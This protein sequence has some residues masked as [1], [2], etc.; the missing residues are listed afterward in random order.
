[1][2]L[3]LS[4]QAL[5]DTPPKPVVRDLK[6]RG[7]ERKLDFLRR[8]WESSPVALV[9]T[10]LI[11]IAFGALMLG[12][13]LVSLLYWALGYPEPFSQPILRVPGSGSYDKFIFLLSG[14]LFTWTIFIPMF[15][16]FERLE[17]PKGSEADEDGLQI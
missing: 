10:L 16:W 11:G 12:G 5:P 15:D 4:V 13:F 7:L 14:I 17:M 2:G 1:M 8:S 6:K 9:F 3:C